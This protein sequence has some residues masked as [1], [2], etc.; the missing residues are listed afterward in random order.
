MEQPYSNS[1]LKRP[2]LFFCL[3]TALT[4]GSPLTAAAAEPDTVQWKTVNMDEVIVTG[5]KQN[6][7]RSEAAAVSSL[8]ARYLNRHEVN[9]VKE[10]SGT[11]PNFFMPDYGSRQTSPIYIRGI[12]SR[13][14]APSVGFYIDGIPR[15]ER[16]A[17]DIDLSDISNMEILRGPQGTLYG[18][19]A[20]GGIINI[21]THSPLEYQSTRFRVGYGSRNDLRLFASTYNKLSEH[22]GISASG[23]YHR[24]DG[25]FTNL[26][27]GKKADNTNDANGRI[28]VE[29]KPREEW[30]IRLHA[31]VD[32]TKQGGYPYGLY[33]TQSHTVGAVDYN[34]P[35]SYRRVV[36]GSGLSIRYTGRNISVDSRTA[37]QYIRDK[38][39][40]D[41]DFTPERRTFIVQRLKQ[42]MVSQEITA[43]GTGNH[44]YGHISGVFGFY[45]VIN[46]DVENQTASTLKRYDI[47]TYGFAFYHQSSLRLFDG[48]SLLAGIRYDNE[49]ARERL[50]GSLLHFHQFT[51][52]VTLQYTPANR[53]L[54]Y[55]SVT[56]GYKT[57]GFNTAFQTDDDR[58]YQPEYSWNYEL[59]AKL[60][61]W[62]RRLEADLSLFFIDW[63]D[64]QITQV[65]P[66]TGNILRNAGRSRSR[67]VELSL[68]ARPIDRLQLVLNYG[69][70]DA[71]FLR[72]NSGTSDY[73]HH[74]LPLVPQHT[75]AINADYTWYAP[76]PAIDHLTISAGVTGVGRIYWH[77]DNEVSQPFY[78]CL[79]AKVSATKGRFTWEMWTKNL[80][81]THYLSYYF[82]LSGK[83]YAQQGKPFTIGTSI[84]F[85]L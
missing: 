18:R 85:T 48:V 21:Y 81:N 12:G 15:F 27:T 50:A 49:Q 11:L 2:V 69:F 10:L 72:Y 51:P 67:G 70:T 54:L 43:K 1:Y 66:G 83:G 60:S 22:V 53:Q 52:K 47:P 14:N 63:R 25:F 31:T 39:A 45:Q 29:W 19:N 34:D 42:Q 77:E 36:A 16:S 56:R 61:F 40:I 13:V 6:P 62:Q 37:Y 38:Q 84:L 76:C 23:N 26:Y 33:D 28:G 17:L 79:D 4:T 68:Q 65:V 80:T 5:F 8:S 3:W 20:I 30:L 73:A 44:R 74:R 9:S 71:R 46:R 64:Q 32:Y 58:T 57:G 41:Q 59:G 75:L 55:A 82:A 24:N 35:G 78:A 7:N